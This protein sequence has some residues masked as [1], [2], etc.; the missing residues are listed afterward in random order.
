MDQHASADHRIKRRIGFVQAES[1]PMKLDPLKS[2]LSD[3]L[4]SYRQS[5]F[6]QVDTHNFRRRLRDAGQKQRHFANAG[7]HIEDPH[8]RAEANGLQQMA[9]MGASK[10]L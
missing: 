7:T 6:V 5:R 8:A 1:A 10:R 3:L 4:T 2:R 9:V